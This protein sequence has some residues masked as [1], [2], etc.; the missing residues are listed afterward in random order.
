[1]GGGAWW[2]TLATWGVENRT[3]GL[4]VNPG[5]RSSTRV[6]YR[7]AAADMNP[8]IAMAAS[9]ASGLYGIEREL[10][11]PSETVGNGYDA[12]AEP[13]PGSPR[14]ATKAPAAAKEARQLPGETVYDNYL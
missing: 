10:A 6:E 11:L 3:A 14:D 9:V 8:Y 12:E 5:S 1:M 4:R 7:F 2:P 13:L